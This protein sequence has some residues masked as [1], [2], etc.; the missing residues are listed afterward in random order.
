MQRSAAACFGSFYIPASCTPTTMCAPRH[1]QMVLVLASALGLSINHSTFVCTRVNEPLMT[2]VAGGLGKGATA[3][4]VIPAHRLRGCGGPGC[5][6]GHALRLQCSMGCA[7]SRLLP[8]AVPLRAGN[9]KN[10]IMTI[11]GA[12]AFGDFVFDPWNAAG[13]AVSMAGAMW[14]ATRSAL[15]VSEE[16]PSMCATHAPCGRD[17]SCEHSVACTVAIWFAPCVHAGPAEICQRRPS[18]ADAGHRA[19][20]IEA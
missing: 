16:T 3:A 19:G 5:G 12:F 15:K 8:P 13:L 17:I 4:G 10:A 14:Y 11:V 9:L 20:P 18:T 2:S 1:A 6:S 7:H